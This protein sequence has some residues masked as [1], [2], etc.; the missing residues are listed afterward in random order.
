MN[1][2]NIMFISLSQVDLP[3]YTEN[4]YID[5]VKWGNDNCFPYYL[6]NLNN[7]SALHGA[8]VSSKV[9][10][11]IGDGFTYD[12]KKDNKTDAFTTNV[13]PNDTIEDFFS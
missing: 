3:T 6:Q 7:R 12:K 8:I 2:D 10:N 9:D 13:N 5:W 11:I 1:K 4:P